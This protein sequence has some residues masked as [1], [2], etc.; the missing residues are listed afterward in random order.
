MNLRSPC[1]VAPQ[2][3]L[4]HVPVDSG[5]Q[6]LLFVRGEWW[7]WKAREY[8]IQDKDLHLGLVCSFS[9]DRS[10]S[11]NR[12]LTEASRSRLACFTRS[13]AAL[14]SPSFRRRSKSASS[15]SLRPSLVA[16]CCSSSRL[17]TNSAWQTSPSAGRGGKPS[18][19]LASGWVRIPVYPVNL[20]PRLLFGRPEQTLDDCNA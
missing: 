11:A 15:S 8:L 2:C 9:Q 3:L 6:G 10:N 4:P 13:R 19:A 12:A 16:R 14:S 17:F 7:A 1:E 5:R 20:D 18:F